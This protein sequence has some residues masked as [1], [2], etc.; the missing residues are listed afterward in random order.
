MK[1]LL[2]VL[3]LALF[4]AGTAFPAI[5]APE[6][7]LDSAEVLQGQTAVLNLSISGGTE[8]YAGV[9]AKIR[10]PLGVTVSSVPKGAVLAS[11]F[12]ADWYASGSDVAVIAYSTSSTFSSVGA[13][14]TLNLQASY[15]TPPGDNAITFV[16]DTSS[17]SNPNALS[18]SDGSKSI[19][20]TVKNGT[21]TVLADIDKDGLWDE[22]EK[23]YFGNLDE[24]ADGDPDNDDFT[25]LEEYNNGTNPTE[26]TAVE[27]GD[28]DG[29]GE[30]KLKDAIL[31]LKVVSG[32]KPEGVK[33]GADVAN[34]EGE[35]K[36]GM[37][38]VIFILRKLADK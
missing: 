3:T 33:L 14:F 36:I 26:E 28:V 5:A 15:S 10:L 12:T 11:G 7:S 13:L 1:A 19:L 29:D 31:A 23:Q 35:K 24:T 20:P 37:E 18:N 17:L 34:K 22:W 38:E 21:L 32:G 2:T 6:L 25:N 9:N 16:S 4:V 27:P 30:I 8:A